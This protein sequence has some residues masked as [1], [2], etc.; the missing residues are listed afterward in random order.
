MLKK[1]AVVL[2]SLILGVLLL[3]YFKVLWLLAPQY[4][5]QD[6]PDLQVPIMDMQAY[7]EIWNTHRRPYIYTLGSSSG[8][9]AFIL[10]IEHTKDPEHSDLDSI[11]Y[12]WA[13]ADPDLALIEGNGGNLFT[14]LQDPVKELGEGGLV[15][16]LANRHG[17][18]AYSWEPKRTQEIELLLKDFSA[19]QLAMFYSFRPYFSNMRYGRPENP[20]KKLQEY[21]KSRTDYPHLRNIFNSWEEL[22]EKWQTDFPGIDWRDYSSG[23]GYPAGYLHAIWNRSNLARDEHMI[24]MILE[25]TAQGKDVFVTMGSSHAPRIEAT[26]RAAMR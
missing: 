25:L 4:V 5:V 13:L 1:I 6:Y 22:D 26:L 2:A 18:K 24:Q 10:G 15:R 14:W 9:K 8:G 21:L 20:E 12:Y 16:Y 19:E 11:R 23:S 7:E 17:V 3:I